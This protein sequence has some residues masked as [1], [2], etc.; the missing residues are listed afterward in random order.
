MD[1]LNTKA[2][3]EATGYPTDLLDEHVINLVDAIKSSNRGRW[4]GN[5]LTIVLII[6][7]LLLTVVV[8]KRNIILQSENNTLREIVNQMTGE[9]CK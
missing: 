5:A 8:F 2:V 6:V 1:E 7:S 4:I 3:K 9:G